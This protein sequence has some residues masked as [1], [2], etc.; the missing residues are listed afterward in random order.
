MPTII[1]VKGAKGTTYKAMVRKSGHPNR[2]KTF[3]RKSQA[4]RWGKQLEA[5]MDSGDSIES[6]EAAKHTLS[7]AIDRYIEGP[8]KEKAPYTQVSQSRQLDWWRSELGHV[9]LS[10]LKPPMIVEARDRLRNGTTLRG[11]KRSG[12]TANRYLAVLSHLFT[13]A[14]KEWQ[15]VETNPC[16]SVGKLKEGERRERVLSRDE[17]ARLIEA[18]RASRNPHL[19]CI[20]E[21]AL[22]TGMR[23]GEILGLTW[24]DIDLDGGWATL[25]KTKNKSVRRVPIMGRA[26]DLLRE[27]SKLRRIDTKLCF[28]RALRPGSETK[29]IVTRPAFTAALK[30][31]G[32]DDGEVCFHTTRHTACTEMASHG[33]TPSEIGAVIGHKTLQMVS[34]YSHVGDEHIRTRLMRVFGADGEAVAGSRKA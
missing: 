25:R 28:P 30:R 1:E 31:A 24:P 34:R 4:V 3:P 33:L 10:L 9:K 29:P 22:S 7:Q 27:K 18:C 14:K 2:S 16:E 32:L 21:I 23:H 5:K 19:E 8:L 20:V 15:W 6:N 26:L 11:G 12:S 13:K 17:Q